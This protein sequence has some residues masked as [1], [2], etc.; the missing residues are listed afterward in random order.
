MWLDK[1]RKK[2]RRNA[3]KNYSNNNNNNMYATKNIFG[4]QTH[5][6]IAIK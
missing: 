4:S 6:Y 1:T 2:H 5:Y 3:K